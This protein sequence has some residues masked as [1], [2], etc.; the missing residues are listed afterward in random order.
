MEY[1]Q[2]SGEDWIGGLVGSERG[3]P[4]CVL[5]QDKWG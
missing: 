5:T 3:C 4:A 1:W 2:I